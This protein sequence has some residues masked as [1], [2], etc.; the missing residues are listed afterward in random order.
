MHDQALMTHLMSKIEQL[1]LPENA[2]R[3]RTIPVSLGDLLHITPAHFR[4]HFD[5]VAPGTIAEG[6]EV[7][8]T[9]ETD[10]TADDAQGIRLT[11]PD[12][13]YAD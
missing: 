12:V 4:K 6:T 5:E 10:P 8:A 11:N 7:V 3:V 2:T 13:E 1:A 9:G